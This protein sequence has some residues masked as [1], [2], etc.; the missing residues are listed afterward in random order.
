MIGKRSI[1]KN[2]PASPLE[3]FLVAFLCQPPFP[4]THCHTGEVW[5][6]TWGVHEV[7]VKR[8]NAV[9]FEFDAEGT[10]KE[11]QDEINFMRS[12]RHRN[13]VLFLG[14]GSLDGVPFLVTE[15]TLRACDCCLLAY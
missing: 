2:H 6:A 10:S 14:A 9:L 1:G 15:Y 11:F 3:K 4:F 13:V 5:L 7:A 12:I 8:L